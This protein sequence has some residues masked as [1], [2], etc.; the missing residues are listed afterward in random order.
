MDSVDA[1]G[2]AFYAAYWIWYE[3]AFEGFVAAASGESWREL[4]ESG[5]S[6]PVVHAEID[7]RQPLHL[8]DQVT[9]ELRL[10]EIGS[11]SIHFEAR[12][13]R[14]DEELAKARTVHVC[15]SRDDLETV[16]MPS[17]LAPAVEGFHQDGSP[18]NRR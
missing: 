12:F 5:L 13:L 10:A 2:I 16:S 15:A 18:S 14:D 17:W 8:S 11:R 7:Y 4:V 6:M 9:V 3:R 1:V